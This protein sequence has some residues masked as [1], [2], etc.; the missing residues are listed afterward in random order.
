MK[1]IIVYYLC[2]LFPLVI[3]FLVARNARSNIFALMI[4]LYFFYRGITD[5]TKKVLYKKKNFGKSLFLF[6][7]RNILKNFILNSNKNFRENRKFLFFRIWL[8]YKSQVFALGFFVF[9]NIIQ[10][11]VLFFVLPSYYLP[12]T[13]DVEGISREKIISQ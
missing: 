1:N 6:G 13:N 7:G 9:N 4:L 8:K 10:K 11:H 12:K 3:M 2:I 5:Y